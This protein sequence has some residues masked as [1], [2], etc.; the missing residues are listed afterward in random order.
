MV[1]FG[2][3]PCRLA[4]QWAGGRPGKLERPAGPPG[5]LL[6]TSWDSRILVF[7]FSYF[8]SSYSSFSRRELSIGGGIVQH[9]LKGGRFVKKVY[10]RSTRRA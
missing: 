1:P 4:S 8:R 2:Q 9:G 6:A 3:P 10:F 7:R 5:G